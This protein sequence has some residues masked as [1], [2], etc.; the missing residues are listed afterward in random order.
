[1]RGAMRHA[2]THHHEDAGSVS[3][4]ANKWVVAAILAAAAAFM[5]VSI[6]YKMAG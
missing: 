4:R 1:M 6:L 5:Y 3:M 2:R